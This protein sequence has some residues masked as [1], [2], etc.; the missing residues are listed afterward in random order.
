MVHLRD[1][2]YCVC[3]AQEQ[4]G[5]GGGGEL[6]V[7]NFRQGLLTDTAVSWR[8]IKD[9]GTGCSGEC[10][11][12]VYDRFAD[13]NIILPTAYVFILGAGINTVAAPRRSVSL[14]CLS[15]AAACRKTGRC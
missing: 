14:S 11:L 2:V 8:C 12:D 5:G 1:C 7:V 10:A 6:V 15:L 4:T 9:G 3:V 13:P